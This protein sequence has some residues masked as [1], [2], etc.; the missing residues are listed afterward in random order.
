MEILLIILKTK[1]K[2]FHIITYSYNINCNP[3]ENSLIKFI[4]N[5]QG[6]N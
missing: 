1:L 5:T 3:I 4:L 2:Y 6:E